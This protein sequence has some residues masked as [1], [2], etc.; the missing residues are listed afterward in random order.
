M[1]TFERRNCCSQAPV[2]DPYSLNS[3]FIA[4]IE[5]EAL[6]REQRSVFVPFFFE[7]NTIFI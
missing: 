2:V 7:V 1:K 3:C 4:G 6:N 5:I